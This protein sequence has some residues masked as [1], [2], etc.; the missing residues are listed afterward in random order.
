MMQSTMTLVDE[1]ARTMMCPRCEE[2]Q[3]MRDYVTLGMSPRYS[4]QLMP[5]Y[6]CRKCHHLF[7][8]REGTAAA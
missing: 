3:P 6:R 8:V 4:T 5:I 1:Q 7:A 2:C